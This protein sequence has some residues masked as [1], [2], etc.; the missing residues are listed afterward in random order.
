MT[1]RQLA[2]LDFVQAY[3]ENDFAIIGI[4]CFWLTPHAPVPERANLRL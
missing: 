1:E 3:D 2:A 4:E